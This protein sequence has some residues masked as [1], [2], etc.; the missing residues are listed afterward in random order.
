MDD[1]RV[2]ALGFLEDWL[3]WVDAGADQG[4]PYERYCGLCDNYYTWADHGG[5]TT[6]IAQATVIPALLAA[7]GLDTWNPF[8]TWE[9]CD[10]RIDWARKTVAKLEAEA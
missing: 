5:H 1:K 6:T 2:R 4:G 10:E 8:G 9:L 7:D 3:A